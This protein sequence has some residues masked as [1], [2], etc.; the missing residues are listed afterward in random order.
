M[1]LAV[2]IRTAVIEAGEVLYFAGGGLV[3]ASDVERE[4]AETELKARSVSGSAR[5]SAWKEF[6]LKVELFI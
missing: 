1:S 4:I 6:C 3:S 5:R 2:A